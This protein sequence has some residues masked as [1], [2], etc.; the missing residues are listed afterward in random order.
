[1]KLKVVD[2][3]IA[4]D[5]AVAC[6][7]DV[8]YHVA[9]DVSL[10][11]DVYR[12]EAAATPLP[13][14]VFVHG[15]LADWRQVHDLKDWGQYRSW[16]RLVAA[17]GMAAVTFNHRSAQQGARMSDVSEDIDA[18]L[19]FLRTE[20]AN[21]GVDATRLALVAF[22]MGVPYTV[23]VAFERRDELACVVA[24]Y[25]FLDLGE[26]GGEI[27]PELLREFS[28]L[29][30]LRAGRRLPPLLVVR[31]GSDHP[32]LNASID[33][34]VAAA[35]VDNLE[36][37]VLNHPAGG[38]GF[39]IGVASSRSRAIIAA[40]LSFLAHHLSPSDGTDRG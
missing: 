19:N 6:T 7:A 40:V 21:L 18:V 22:S 34:F 36:I 20:G 33:R 38:H 12:P 29:D 37:D 8:V 35:L 16:G 30:Q 1:M 5:L 4:P 28:P 3:A 17:S 23:R 26:L 13:A 25:G 24:F 15:D 2:H 9:D 32:L 14:A 31:A 39:D 10:T 11:L 27:K